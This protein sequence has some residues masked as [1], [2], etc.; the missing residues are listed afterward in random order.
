VPAL[1]NPETFAA[2]QEGL[3][4]RAP[5]IVAPRRVTSPYLLSGLLRCGECHG[6]EGKGDGP[7]AQRYERQPD[8][9]VRIRHLDRQLFIRG[10]E[11]PDLFLTLRTGLDGT[12]MG[13]YDGLPDEDIWALAVFV[14]D[15]LQQPPR[16]EPPARAAGSGEPP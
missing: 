7:A 5:K 9:Q 12:P 10:A 15:G 16:S 2:I 1:V 8:R 14:R 4:A 6:D 11:L 3:R 13:A